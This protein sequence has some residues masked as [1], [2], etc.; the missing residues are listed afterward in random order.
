MT[1]R[2]VLALLLTARG[3]LGA[4]SAAEPAA[5][6]TA[7]MA[8]D[9]TITLQLRAELPGG[10]IGEG[11]LV[12]PPNHPQYREILAHIGGLRP[13]ETKPVP[14]WPDPPPPGR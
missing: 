11:V 2:Q 12:Y 8:P 14:P 6:G 4:A 1:R 13:G 7:T 3:M 9:G 10:G 5:I